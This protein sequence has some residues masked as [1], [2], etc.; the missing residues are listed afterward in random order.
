MLLLLSQEG[1]VAAQKSLFPLLSG[2]WYWSKS[3]STLYV[4]GSWSFYLLLVF[5]V[6]QV[7]YET[8]KVVFLLLTKGT[9]TI[10]TALHVPTEKCCLVT[11]AFLASYLTFPKILVWT[12]SRHLHNSYHAFSFDL[13]YWRSEIKLPDYFLCN[14]L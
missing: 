7:F 13:S 11:S 2:C 8:Q 1:M 6:D 3:N 4:D 9:E 14:H 10:Q 12:K 5:K